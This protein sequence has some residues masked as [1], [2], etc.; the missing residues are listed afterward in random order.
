MFIHLNGPVN[1]Y[2]TVKH[3]LYFSGSSVIM[4]AWDWNTWAPASVPYATHGTI[5]VGSNQGGYTSS[6]NNGFFTDLMT[7]EYH[8]NQHYGGEL[9]ALYFD[10]DIL[11]ILGGCRPMNIV[12]ILIQIHHYYSRKI[13]LT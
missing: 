4:S 8:V 3:A 2:D 12:H 6:N 7:E 9:T 10:L 1:S 5:F 11:L 13:R